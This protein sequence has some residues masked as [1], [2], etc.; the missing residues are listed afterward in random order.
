[1]PSENKRN[2]TGQSKT[3]GTQPFHLLSNNNMTPKSSPRR[4]EECLA[5]ILK[6]ISNFA[7]SHQRQRCKPQVGIVRYQHKHQEGSSWFLS[8]LDSKSQVYK[9]EKEKTS[10][11][12]KT[13]RSQHISFKCN[14]GKK[15]LPTL[16][17]DIIFY[18]RKE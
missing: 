12:P 3:S 13:Q 14:L 18:K 5:F 4:L 17:F 16:A 10:Q 1:M 7:R 9:K 11:Q 6:M 15:L 8:L 2:N